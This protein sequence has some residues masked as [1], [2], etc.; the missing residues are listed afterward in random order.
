[1]RLHPKN[2]PLGGFLRFW[3]RNF[4]SQWGR[5]LLRGFARRAKCC[6]RA[7]GGGV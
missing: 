4:Y 1:M 3:L 2:P 5:L 7:C 6:E